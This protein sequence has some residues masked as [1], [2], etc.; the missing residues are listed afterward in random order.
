MACLAMALPSHGV[1]D[2]FDL[3]VGDGKPSSP[4]SGGSALSAS[5]RLKAAVEAMRS[6]GIEARVKCS[7]LSQDPDERDEQIRARLGSLRGSLTAGE[8]VIVLTRTRRRSSQHCFRLITGYDAARDTWIYQD[9]EVPLGAN[10]EMT[11]KALITVWTIPGEYD[12]R[13]TLQLPVPAPGVKSTRMA[14]EVAV[15]PDWSEPSLDTDISQDPDEGEKNDIEDTEIQTFL[16]APLPPLPAR[17]QN[18][19]RKQDTNLNNLLYVLTKTTTQIVLAWK[20]VDNAR[21]YT[22]ERSSSSRGFSSPETIAILPPDVTVYGD[23]GIPAT[24]SARFRMH[25]L[26]AG[27][28]LLQ[29][30]D[31]S[32]RLKIHL[33]NGSTRLSNTVIARPSTTPTRGKPD[34]LYADVVLGQCEFTELTHGTPRLTDVLMGGGLA[35]DRATRP[36]RLWVIDTLTNRVLGWNHLGKGSRTSQPCTTDGDLASGDSCVIAAGTTPADRVLGQPDDRHT[37][38]NGDSTMTQFPFDPEPGART[39]SYSRPGSLSPTESAI[40]SNLVIDSEHSVFVPDPSNNRIL[41]FN[42]PFGT[43]SDSIADQVWGQNGD[44]SS[45]TANNG[46]THERSLALRDIMG[47]DLDDAGNLWVT[48]SFNHRVLRY[49]RDP[50]S[51]QIAGAADLVIGQK[52][53]TLNQPRQDDSLDA[54][55]FP[56]AVRADDQGNIFVLEWGDNNRSGGAGCRLIR[57]DAADLAMAKSE[58]QPSVPAREVLLPNDTC[59]SSL[60]WQPGG[61]TFDRKRGGLWILKVQGSVHFYSLAARRITHRIGSGSGGHF[62]SVD[63]DQEGNVYVIDTHGRN[64]VQRYDAQRVDRSTAE[65][66]VPREECVGVIPNRQ[67]RDASSLADVTGI[68]VSGEQIIATDR[69]RLI[70]WNDRSKIL[71]GSPVGHPADGFWD[72]TPGD[73]PPLFAFPRTDKAGRLWVSVSRRTSD[74]GD[75]N[76]QRLLQFDLPLKGEPKPSREIQISRFE[77]IERLTLH[78]RYQE[79]ISIAPIDDGDRVWIADEDRGRV[80]RLVNLNGKDNKDRGPYVDVIIGRPDVGDTDPFHQPRGPIDAVS[81]SAVTS[82]RLDESGNLW[83]VDRMRGDDGIGT[84]LLRFDSK[85]I[86]DKPARTVC[87]IRASAVF[88]TSGRFDQETRCTGT[89][90]GWGENGCHPSLPIWIKPGLMVLGTNPYGNSRFPLVYARPDQLP[91]PVFALGDVTGSTIDS[92]T[93]ADGNLYL[94]DGN[95]NRILIYRKPFES[96]LD[97]PGLVSSK[98]L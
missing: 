2:S 79:F 50:E 55:H 59:D 81:C 61:M 98:G 43:G 95:W 46:G 74:L 83:V 21:S 3:L 27:R 70:Y 31:S 67:H 65:D 80:V 60:L 37:S 71:T 82:I 57:Y 45:Q 96:L 17:S 33:E 92:C 8:P 26:K 9:P 32:Y 68:T 77:T 56:S 14:S 47:I 51:G 20:S 11:S 44:F 36:Q 66:P 39:L 42:D 62:Q 97:L 49:P 5:Q 72:P 18:T 64:S 22:L 90:E 76:P 53:F 19:T 41:R 63:L 13:F 87:G 54:L 38:S 15:E 88:G 6:R 16:I 12:T 1:S 23:T 94:G 29:D 78:P 75:E 34:D 35:V 24:Q 30:T 48:D 91:Q 58:G 10:R 52:D 84:R 89:G 73:V 86:P 7:A 85:D 28:G 93:D 69:Y 4:R 25:N 40:Y